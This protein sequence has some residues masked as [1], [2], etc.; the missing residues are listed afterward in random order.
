MYAKKVKGEYIGSIPLY[1]YLK[2]PNDHHKL[3]VDEGVR[4]NIEYIYSLALEGYSP[5][6]IA[7][8]F[9]RKHIPIPVIYKNEIRGKEITEN[10]GYGIWKRQTIKNILTNQMYIGNMVQNKFAKVSYNSKKIKRMNEEEYIIVENTHEAI[11]NK[12]DYNKVQKL[13]NSRSCEK[14]T[15]KQFQ[16]LLGGMLYCKDC[17]RTIRI[18]EKIMK[19]MTKHYTQ[20]NLYTRKGKF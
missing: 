5:T 2:D 19:S 3:I 10:D 12:D 7:E 8:L 15:A 13:L 17:G 6:K 18:S 1:G 4:D 9:T 16:Y 11:I 20:C 14:R